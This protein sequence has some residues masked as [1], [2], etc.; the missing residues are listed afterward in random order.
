MVWTLQLII[1][2]V[3]FSFRAL[4]YNITNTTNST[5][6]QPSINADNFQYRGVALG[7]WLLLEPYITPSLFLAFNATANTTEGDIPIDE[8]RYCE[9]LGTTEA[10]ERLGSH[11]DTWITEEDFVNI[12]SVGLNMVRIPVGYWSFIK[13]PDDPYVKG[14]QDYLDDA[15]GWAK[16]YDLKVWIDL[17]GVPGSQNGFDNSGYRDIGFPGWQN[18]SSYIEHSYKVLHLIYTKYGTESYKDTVIGIEVVNEP[19]GPLLNMTMVEEFYALTYKD[20]RNTQSLNNTIVFHD[21][22]QSLGFW[23]DV[24]VND[25]TANTT[26][27]RSQ[28]Y[29]ILVD[30]HHYEVFTV[31]GLNLTIAEHINNIKS[32]SSGI[33]EENIPAVV[34]EWSAALTDCTPWLNG[35]GIG[36]RWEGTS[37][38][39]NAPL[40]KCANVNNWDKWLKKEKKDHCKWI[41]IQLDQYSSKT[42]GWIFWCWKTES[43][44]EWD[45]QRLVNLGL[46]PQPL[47]NFTYISNGTDIDPD[48]SG[49]GRIHSNWYLL[50]TLIAVVLLV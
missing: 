13:Y 8:Y 40:G 3:W 18:E 16:K 30:H 49:S 6:I 42:K 20:A 22:F 38:Y 15:I 4:A 17:H 9:K 11:W 19:L 12:S 48:K 47:D 31:G 37:P 26:T 36:T 14:A 25:Y 43:T 50:G 5:I 33:A 34:G 41:E 32:Y 24:L 23:D 2:A 28:Y 44:I 10:Q 1:V 45:F 27:K 35:V 46:M 7:G 29:N 39:D 21:A